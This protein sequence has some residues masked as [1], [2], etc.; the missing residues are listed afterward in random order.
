MITRAEVVKLG[1]TVALAVGG[2]FW[3]SFDTLQEQTLTQQHRLKVIEEEL[4]D[5]A[6]F[7]EGFSDLDERLLTLEFREQALE[8]KI[9]NSI[10][11]LSTST[12]KLAASTNRLTD[13]VIRLDERV[14]FIERDNRK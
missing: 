6:R 14:K 1:S 4:D 11:A 9:D 13:V 12:D 3:V 8:E 5:R 10:A 2:S 7:V